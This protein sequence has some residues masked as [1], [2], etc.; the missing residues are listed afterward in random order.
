M[1][2]GT[3]VGLVGLLSLMLGIRH[4]KMIHKEEGI[5]TGVIGDS[6]IL[7]IIFEGL[8]WLLD[9]LP[10]WVTRILFLSLAFYCF[11]WSYRLFTD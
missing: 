2:W 1:L 11:Y 3:L 4:N 10:Y 8:R 6:I 5:G 7:E 9:K